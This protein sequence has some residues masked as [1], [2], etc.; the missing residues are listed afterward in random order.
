MSVPTVFPS[1]VTVY[2]PEKCWNGY[3]LFQARGEGAVLIDMTGREIHKW[4]G[5]CGMPN[6]MLPDGSLI[7]SVTDKLVHRG[8]Q[9]LD[10]MVHV[11]WDGEVQWAFNQACE[12][13]DPN[14]NT[15]WSACQHHDFDIEGMPTGYYSPNAVPKKDGKLLILAHQAKDLPKISAST[16]F[17]DWIYEV[18]R[19]GN[20]VW[21]WHA[22]DHYEELGFRDEAKKA[23]YNRANMMALG[24]ENVKQQQR[25]VDWL[26]I[27]CASYLGPNKW[28]DQGDMRFHPDNI[29]VD[30]RE[31]N[32]LMII[33]HETGEVVW[34]VGPDYDEGASKKLGWIVGPH[35]TH[36]I[37]RG[38]PG[39]GNILVF[40]NG[41]SAGY[42]AP[43]P[44]APDGVY[45]VHRTY[46][47][48]IEFDPVTLEMVWQYV[49]PGGPG[50]AF[51]FLSPNVSSAQRLPNGN[52]FVDSGA[53]GLLFELT[54]E[55]ERV[56]EYASPYYSAG[57]YAMVLGPILSNMI[58]RAYRVPYEW[59]KDGKPDE[60]PIVKPRRSQF[61]V[62][63]SP[64][65]ERVLP[66]EVKL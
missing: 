9:T 49:M 60:T 32:I 28:Y 13:T 52:T 2:N 16:L 25:L 53:T 65:M 34:R 61:R 46:S 63:G 58:Y 59:A 57:E 44:M 43:N 26:H 1:G 48:V 39:E 30:S 36:M 50:G 55:G 45:T 24:L 15:I 14:G 47:R 31:A 17:D 8:E 42:G 5:V 11:D 18:D 27:N 64:A 33:S 6:K 29:I 4:S 54:P 19:D 21:Q 23:I 7:T 22:G 37:P 35:H 51:A 56:W 62:P 40:D 10:T 12:V 41:G 38:L 3:T 20:I 66:V